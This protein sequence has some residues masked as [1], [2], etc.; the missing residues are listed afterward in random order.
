MKSIVGKV[1]SDDK[2]NTLVLMEIPEK[3]TA[4]EAFIKEIDV[5]IATKIF[6]LSYAQAEDLSK[7]IGEALTKNVGSLKFDKRSNKIIVTDTPQ[8]LEEITGMIQAFDERHEEVLIQ[9]KII[10]IVLSDQYKLGV[11]WEAIVSNYHRLDLNS[12]FNILGSA[13]KR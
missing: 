8:K 2:S 12:G 13:D 1:I 11:D 9:A 7:K 3:L 10:Q 4:M 5:P 6:E